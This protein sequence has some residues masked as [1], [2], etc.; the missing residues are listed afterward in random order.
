MAARQLWKSLPPVYRQCAVAYTDFSNAYGTVLP[1][2]RHRAVGKAKQRGLGGFHQTKRGKHPTMRYD[3]KL[4]P[5][6]YAKALAS[7]RPLGV[8]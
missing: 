5:K 3:T 4:Y 1:S 2:K 8:L 6:V 7:R